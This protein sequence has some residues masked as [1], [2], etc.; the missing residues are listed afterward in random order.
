MKGLIL[1][2]IGAE[3]RG[4]VSG[5]SKTKKV[6][7]GFAGGGERQGKKKR[8]KRSRLLRAY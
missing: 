3:S 5:G 2:K 8:K 4:G 7:R 6:R 1:P